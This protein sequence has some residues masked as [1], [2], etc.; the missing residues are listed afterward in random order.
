MNHRYL[1]VAAI[2]GMTTLFAAD[3]LAQNGAAS[4]G[5]AASQALEEAVVTV[6]RREMNIQDVPLAVSVL[7]QKLHRRLGELLEARTE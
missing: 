2:T 6:E 3:V 4:A 7:S 1:V 5:P